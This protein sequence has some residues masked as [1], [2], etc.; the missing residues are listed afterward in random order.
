MQNHALGFTVFII[1]RTCWFPRVLIN[2][3]FAYT[4]RELSQGYL[5]LL[6]PRFIHLK[7]NQVS[8]LILNST[9]PII[10]KVN[11]TFNVLFLD[12]S[13]ILFSF[14][15][16]KISKLHE[17]IR[18]LLVTRL[19]FQWKRFNYPHNEQE[20]SWS[21]RICCNSAPL[22]Q[23]G[24]FRGRWRNIPPSSSNLLYNPQIILLRLIRNPPCNS[25]TAFKFAEKTNDQA[26]EK[27]SRKIRSRIFPNSV[28]ARYNYFNFNFSQSCKLI[29]LNHNPRYFFPGISLHNFNDS[30]FLYQI[31]GVKFC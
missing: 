14:R 8:I 25:N 28:K 2:I 12:R 20:T 26:C 27:P 5:R 6:S 29:F 23:Q 15:R 18:K 1:D 9:P 11:F 19:R 16:R 21:L 7:K 31:R 30:L 13:V 24:L 10:S 3:S 22:L 4:S 17:V